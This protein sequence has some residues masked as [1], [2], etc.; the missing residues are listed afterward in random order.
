MYFKLLP[1]FLLSPI[2]TSLKEG[3][4]ERNSNEKLEIR[5]GKVVWTG[6][7]NGAYPGAALVISQEGEVVLQKGFGKLGWEEN[8]G[9]VDPLHTWYDLASLTK[10]L[11]TTTTLLILVDKG[12]VSLD[13]PA[14]TWLPQWREGDKA[15]ITI[16]Q[17]LM[18]RSGLP[19]GR[20]IWK[21]NGTVEQKREALLQ[22]YLIN[23]PGSKFV[24]SDLGADVLG[25]LIERVTGVSLERAADSLV[26]KPLGL[27]AELTY[28]VPDS[29]HYQ[30]APTAVQTLRGGTLRGEVHDDNA[31]AL[32]GA[33]G[34]SGLF[35]TADAVSKLAAFWLNQ[36]VLAGVRL[37]KP[38]TVKLFTD[39]NIDGRAVGWE[40]C[41]TAGKHKPTCG[42]QM[43]TRAYGHTGFTGTSVWIDPDSKTTVVFL[44]NRVHVPTTKH[45][46]RILADI[47][48]DLADVS[49]GASKMVLRSEAQKGWKDK[50]KKKKAPKKKKRKS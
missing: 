25:F 9:A 2:F 22:T 16:R 17:L 47:R 50:P 33:A 42:K 6:I 20:D 26:F 38:E 13:M 28:R 7:K 49:F 43:G 24:Y 46:Q 39:I 1:I 19:A 36:G 41:I 44:T 32:G 18:H 11:S 48:S 35:G 34:H 45:S 40:R 8:S 27:S 30:A 14:A 5:A 37:V 23:T 29:L 12:E 31:Y 15:N 3:G 4:M 21:I 10:V